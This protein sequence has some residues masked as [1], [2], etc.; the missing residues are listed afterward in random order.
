[1][2]PEQHDID[3][4]G[5][6]LLRKVLGPPNFIVNEVQ[7][8][9]GIDF[10]IQVFDGAS[11]SGAWFHVQL[12]SSRSSEYSA[13]G[14][15]VSQQ[16]PIDHA[17]H[18]ALELRQPVFLFHADV[19]SEHLYWHAPQLDH[20]LVTVLANTGAKFIT[21]RV[22]TRQRLPETAPDMVA[23]LEEI[24]LLI[25]NRK[26]TSISAQ[27]FAESLTHFPDQEKLH[28]AFQ[29]KND[30]LKLQR[31]FASFHQK[32]FNEARQRAEAVLLDPDSTVE[33]KFWA[34]TTLES[35][36]FTLTL[37]AGK[38]Q[39][40]LS[41]IVL[42]HAR[43]LQ[44]LTAPGPKYLKFYSLVAR[45]AAEL[46]VLAHEEFTLFMAL[47]AHLEG[48][49]NPAVVLGTL[50]R[51]SV[52]TARIVSKYNQCVRLARYAAR[53]PDRWM[54]G[55]ALTRIPRALGSYM[56]TLR[57]DNRLE[58]ESAFTRSALQILKLSVWICRETGDSQGIVLA[59]SSA[60][61]IT[62]SIDSDAYRWAKEVGES[63]VDQ[64]TH[65]DALSIIE[66]AT[67][68]WKGESVEGDYHGETVWLIMKNIATALGIDLG[69]ENDPLVRGL[70]LAAKDDSPERILRCCE[71][72]LVTQGAT[73]PIAQTIQSLF[74]TSRASSK[75]IH[76]T[77]HDL[78]L[79]GREQ[80][81][82]YDE[83][84]KAHRDFC[85]D[86]KPRAEDWRY[87]NE[88]RKE[89]E[90]RHRGFVFRLI[91]TPFELRYRN[92]D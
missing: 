45:K 61:S 81:G 3:H 20:Q 68:R 63:L 74:N 36:D 73:G 40:E 42:A 77:L 60:L 2:K 55:R 86:Q 31:I 79:E 24:Q 78:H 64:K 47:K 49:G 26:L 89:F 70:K 5:K 35:I 85:P 76:C 66:R 34:Q 62:Y 11:P 44:K 25:A 54:L 67:R 39:S 8:D 32:K 92:E 53:Y 58:V 87:T 52:V 51:R 37:H 43:A 22:P 90:A 10:N 41:Q 9:Y 28:S 48:P 30:T 72:L 16:L 56:V 83:F 7:D 21:L 50:A 65:D 88:V 91:G 71:H 12:K 23:S 75:V 15:F 27:A 46:E 19:A 69:N 18:Y 33:T 84:R 6:V 38:P 59:I 1:M 13:N 4:A 14:T 80:D 57:S 29:E 17:R 82:T